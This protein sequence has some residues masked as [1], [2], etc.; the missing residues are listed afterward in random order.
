MVKGPMPIEMEGP[1]PIDWVDYFISANDV[2]VVFILSRDGKIHHY[3][4]RADSSAADV[5]KGEA[6]RHD[7]S[8]FWFK[9]AS[10][11]EDAFTTHCSWWH[12]FNPPDTPA[13]PSA[14]PGSDWKCPHCA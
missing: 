12:R 8:F 7:Y 2:P 11:P 6:K 4:G 3:I 9:V 5:I 13:H 10:S 1:Y 14:P